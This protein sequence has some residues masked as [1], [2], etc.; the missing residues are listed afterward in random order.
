MF[1]LFGGIFGRF[2][3]G[4]ILV[5]KVIIPKSQECVSCS[6]SFLGPNTKW[7]AFKAMAAMRSPFWI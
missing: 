6:G 1:F 3:L 2:C 4:G 7:D 5:E